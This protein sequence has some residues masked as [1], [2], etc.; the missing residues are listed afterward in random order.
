MNWCWI[1]PIVVGLITALLGYLMGKSAKQHEVNE[2]KEKYNKEKEELVAMQRKVPLLENDVKKAQESNQK[3]TLAYSELIGRF[4]LLQHAWDKNRTEIQN[5]KDENNE[6]THELVKCQEVLNQAKNQP[7]V[8]DSKITP[9]QFQKSNS[10]NIKSS[11]LTSSHEDEPEPVF[12]AAAA[13]E[14]F[15]RTIFKDDLTIVEGIG[16]KIQELF[17][18]RGVNTWYALSRCSVEECNE[19]LQS[20][21]DRFNLHN[22]GTWPRQAQLAFQGDWT[23]LKLWQDELDGGSSWDR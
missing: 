6:L 5:L 10:D 3:A 16:P 23:E 12:D 9:L 13:N 20:G 4:D 8:T 2:W 22:P 21:G 15:G 11:A 14:A 7:S 1:I 18:Q 19:I 17:H